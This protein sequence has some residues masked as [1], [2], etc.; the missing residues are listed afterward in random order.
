MDIPL[1]AL[2]FHGTLEAKEIFAP[3]GNLVFNIILYSLQ[4]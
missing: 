1:I 3:G 2:P 4:P